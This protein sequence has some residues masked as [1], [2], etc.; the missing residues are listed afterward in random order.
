MIEMQLLESDLEKDVNKPT[1]IYQDSYDILVSMLHSDNQWV[2]IM[3]ID[4]DWNPLSK[5]VI[6]TSIFPHTPLEKPR[7]ITFV[8]STYLAYF[9]R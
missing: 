4:Y 3:R 6:L 1:R 2:I 5:K 7:D 8:T 9:I